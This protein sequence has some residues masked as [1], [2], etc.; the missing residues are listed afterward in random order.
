MT[1]EKAI[2]GVQNVDT[3][4]PGHA[5]D[6]LTWND[7]VEYSAFYNDLVA[8]AEQGKAAGR[9]AAETAA[10]YAAPD[11]YSDFQAPANRVEMIMQ[12]LYD[13]Q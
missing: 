6:P 5:D 9:S 4:I 8:K 10:A 13:G 12:L 2:A 11:Q 7:L 3:L 1:L